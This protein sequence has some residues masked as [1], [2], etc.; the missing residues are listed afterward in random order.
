MEF[1]EPYA[2]EKHITLTAHA[3]P[4]VIRGEKNL[5][6]QAFANLIDN[7]IKFTPHGGK[8]DAT[9]NNNGKYAEVIIADSGAGIPQEY[10]DKVFEKFFR[11]EQSRHTKGNGLG[12]S[13]VTAIAHIHSAN[14]TLEDNEPGLRVRMTIPLS[15]A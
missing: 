9:C 3:A 8:I 14:I 13:L 15:A 4:L 1:Y 12:L 7:A 10:R 5:L 11:M 2:E 6:T